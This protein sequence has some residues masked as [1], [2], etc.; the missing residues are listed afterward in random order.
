MCVV[1]ARGI[2]FSVDS[3]GRDDATTV[4]DSL[5]ARYMRARIAR[6][7]ASP[8]RETNRFIS[9]ILFSPNSPQNIALD[10]SNVN[11]LLAH[12]LPKNKKK[13]YLKNKKRRK[14]LIGKMKENPMG[15]LS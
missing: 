1:G 3:A 4:A 13:I 6:A 9:G 14:N 11:L 2:G 10:R 5:N 15:N 7:Y 8:I 12:S